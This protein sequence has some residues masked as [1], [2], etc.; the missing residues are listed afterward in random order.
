MAKNAQHWEKTKGL[1]IVTLVLWA[2][3]S[4]GIFLFGA[5]MNT[6]TGPFGY[7][8]TYWFTCQGSLGFF[9]ILIFMNHKAEKLIIRLE[10]LINMIL[11]PTC[12]IY[13][14]MEP[15]AATFIPKK[16]SI[17]EAYI[18]GHKDLMEHLTFIIL[19][20]CCCLSINE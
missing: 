9:V 19:I 7:P 14:N 13:I 20:E 15:C 16:N 1:L 5:E 3:F 10:T 8:L 17:K 2:I 6:V 12:H 4:M 11:Q 18:Y